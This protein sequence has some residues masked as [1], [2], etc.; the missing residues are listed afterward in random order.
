MHVPY[1]IAILLKEYME[2]IGK[3]LRFQIFATDL[4][5]SAINRAREGIYP[6]SIAADVSPGRLQRFFKLEDSQY[7]ISKEIRETVIFATHNL[8]QAPPFTRIDLIS[9]RNLLIYRYLS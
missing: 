6:S 8:I 2:K 5:E 3:T 9:C 1:S 7:R 4:D